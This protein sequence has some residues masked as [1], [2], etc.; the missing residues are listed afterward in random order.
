MAFSKFRA[1]NCASVALTLTCSFLLAATPVIPARSEPVTGEIYAGASLDREERNSIGG[2]TPSDLE[3]IGPEI[4]VDLVW[5]NFAFGGVLEGRETNGDFGAGFF[6]TEVS[7][8]GGSV[9]V[10]GAYQAAPGTLP[11]F[12]LGLAG[13]YSYD[14]GDV[15]AFGAK[16]DLALESGEISPFAYYYLEFGKATAEFTLS[17]NISEARLEIQGTPTEHLSARNTELLAQ[18]RAPIFGGISMMV[19]IEGRYSFK[20]EPGLGSAARDPVSAKLLGG[21]RFQLTGNTALDLEGEVR[22]ADEVVDNTGL[23][24]RLRRSF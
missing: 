20:E 22:I 9:E 17:A 13:T 2:S 10:Y 18:Y 7:A 6:F 5:G 14:A 1:I 15:Q 8:R 4:G 19:G 12:Y 23:A 11:G 24:I 16:A 21:M 3:S